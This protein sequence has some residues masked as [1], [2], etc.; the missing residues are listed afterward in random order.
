MGG[1]PVGGASRPKRSGGKSIS[2]DDNVTTHWSGNEFNEDWNGNGDVVDDEEGVAKR[3]SLSSKRKNRRSPSHGSHDDSDITTGRDNKHSKSKIK[4]KLKMGNVLKRSGRTQVEGG[5]ATRTRGLEE[6][7]LE[8][9]ASGFREDGGR[10]WTYNGRRR[11]SEMSACGEQ[12]LSRG[13]HSLPRMGSFDSADIFT[14][15]S[16][17]LRSRIVKFGKYFKHDRET[18]DGV[19]V[20][21]KVTRLG[22]YC[23]CVVG[24]THW[25]CGA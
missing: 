14:R 19:P 16:K 25:V 12:Q 24:V 4:L 6:A 9:S 13:H 17:G 20:L 1:A 18:E 5:V 23:V 2:F 10:W 11:T 15:S 8:A 3:V 7:E 21:T 22:G